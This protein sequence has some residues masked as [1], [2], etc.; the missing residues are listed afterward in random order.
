MECMVDNGLSDEDTIE[1]AVTKIETYRALFG[2][3]PQTAEFQSRDFMRL[4]A[5]IDQQQAQAKAQQQQEDASSIVSDYSSHDEATVD[6]PA[7]HVMFSDNPVVVKPKPALS[8]SEQETALNAKRIIKETAESVA[9]AAQTY[10]P[11]QASVAKEA[12]MEE[13]KQKTRKPPQ[14]NDSDSSEEEWRTPNFLVLKSTSNKQS[15]L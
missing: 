1:D 10:Y 15:L 4:T 5:L 9:H 13:V 14:P 12:P 11:K 6:H 2:A 3:A 7:K 8:K